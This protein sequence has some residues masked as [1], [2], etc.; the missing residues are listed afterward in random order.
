MEDFSCAANLR[1]TG[2][3]EQQGE[4]TEQAML[5]VQKVISDNLHL[6]NIRVQHACRNRQQGDNR[7]LLAKLPSAGEKMKCLCVSSKLKEK[8]IYINDDVSAAT[9]ENNRT[10]GAFFCTYFTR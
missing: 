6:S 8:D 5:N 3:R 7:A 9:M 4:F 10:K 1:I 2:I